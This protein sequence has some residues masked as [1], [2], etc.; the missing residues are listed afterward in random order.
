MSNYYRYL[1]AMKEVET[2]RVEEFHCSKRNR[3]FASKNG[4]MSHMRS[5]Q[6]QFKF[7][8]D[9]CKKGFK[10]KITTIDT[11]VGIRARRFRASIVRKDSR[12]TTS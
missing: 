3:N 10:T 4:I 11:W 8:C 5:H 12:M 7:W 6:G 9:Q 2:T 1:T